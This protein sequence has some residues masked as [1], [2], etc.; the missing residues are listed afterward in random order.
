[1]CSFMPHRFGL[2]RDHCIGKAWTVR[3]KFCRL[4]LHSLVPKHVEIAHSAAISGTISHA[5]KRRTGSKMDTGL[6]NMS[7]RLWVLPKEGCVGLYV[8]C[9]PE[10][11]NASTERVNDKVNDNV[12]SIMIPHDAEKSKAA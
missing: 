5:A 8:Q 6:L 7:M 11:N 2:E 10:N 4:L 3:R 12:P 1:M 9:A